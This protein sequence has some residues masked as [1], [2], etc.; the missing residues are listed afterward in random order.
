MKTDP[1]DIILN[2]NFNLNKKFYFISG[3]EVSLIERVSSSIIEKYKKKEDIAKIELDTI[4]NFKHENNLFGGK[5]I[6]FSRN[7][8]GIKDKNIDNLKNGDG[9]FIFAQENSQKTKVL[10][11][12]FKNMDESYVIDC[13]ELNKTSKIKVLNEFLKKKKVKIPEHIYW[14]LIDKLDNRYAFL[15]NSLNKIL[16]IDMY[17]ISID[18]IVRLISLEDSGKESLFFQM[19]KK[20]SEIVKIYKDKIVS[21]TDVDQFYYSCKYFCQLLIDSQNLEDYKK[22]IP[23]YLFKEKDYL[24]EIYRKYNFKK[25]KKILNLLSNME[26]V[27]RKDSNLSVAYGLRFILNIKKITIS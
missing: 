24:I 27:L 9:I 25:K 20:N 5:T 16:D 12:I 3:N 17:D 14:F 23:R 18:N 22:K 2:E 13:Y 10:K 7:C 8:K 1:L 11:E 15:E 19:L 26:R 21:K 6:Y 4:D